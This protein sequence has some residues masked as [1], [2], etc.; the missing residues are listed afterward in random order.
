MFKKIWIWISDF[1][2]NWF[3]AA[4][5]VGIL[6]IILFTILLVPSLFVDNILVSIV[7][8]ICYIFIILSRIISYNKRKYLEMDWFT[9]LP[10]VYIINAYKKHYIDSEDVCNQYR[11]R[12]IEYYDSPT[13]YIV[14]E[15]TK[16]GNWDAVS[17]LPYSKTNKIT[18]DYTSNTIYYRVAL[19]IYIWYLT[20][21]PIEN[22][23]DKKDSIITHQGSN[24][25]IKQ[26]RLPAPQHAAVE[27]IPDPDDWGNY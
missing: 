17:S 3:I 4:P 20:A 6:L 23:N 22:L 24:K 26:K 10:E 9:D 5:L 12:S 14:E 8:L 1:Y 2:Y 19:Y 18:R 27:N 11:L 13:R 21:T 15:L 16:S 25:N 7:I